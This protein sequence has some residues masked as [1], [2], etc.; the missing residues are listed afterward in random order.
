MLRVQAPEA[1]WPRAAIHDTVAAIVRQ[2]AYHRSV[3]T[4]LLDRVWGWIADMYSRLVETLGTVPHGRV[5]ATIAAGTIVLLV[6]ARIV[7]AARLRGISAMSLAS[8]RG[9]S[10]TSSSA[11]PWREAEQLAAAG[12][13][14]EAAHALYRATVAMLAAAGLVRRHESKT[15]GDYA[16]ELRRRGAPAYTAFRRFGGRYDRIIY[17]T[18][19]CDAAAYDAL[20]ADARAVL[21]R[22]SERAA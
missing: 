4:T 22:Q 10:G 1:I 7:Y 19:V 15:S 5:V 17:G 12:Q 8:G 13:F 16:R 20:L 18:G 21:D 2:P 6:V 14:T 9:R 11:D 3:G